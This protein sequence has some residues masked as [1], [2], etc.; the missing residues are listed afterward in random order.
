LRGGFATIATPFGT[1]YPTPI[2][3][4]AHAEDWSPPHPVVYWQSCSVGPLDYTLSNTLLVEAVK[5]RPKAKSKSVSIWKN[6]AN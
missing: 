2:Q 4:L 3:S 5:R 1:N 6:I